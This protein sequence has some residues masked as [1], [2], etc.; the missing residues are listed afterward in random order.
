M[1]ISVTLTIT[2]TITMKL[3][4]IKNVLENTVPFIFFSIQ[5]IPSNNYFDE[6]ERYLQCYIM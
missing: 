6:S 1:L 3:T 4:V 2:L 5:A